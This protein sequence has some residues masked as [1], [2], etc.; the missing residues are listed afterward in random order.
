MKFK[1]KLF[2]TAEDDRGR[3]VLLRQ[4]CAVTHVRCVCARG[5]HSGPPCHVSFSVRFLSSYTHSHT[6]TRTPKVLSSNSMGE[7]GTPLA[8]RLSPSSEFLRPKSLQCVFGGSGTVYRS[9]IVPAVQNSCTK[10]HHIFLVT[11]SVVL[12]SAFSGDGPCIFATSPLRCTRAIG[13]ASWHGARSAARQLCV[14]EG[15]HRFREGGRVSRE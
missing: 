11:L 6:H 9:G 10:Y 3:K 4:A 14:H 12:R 13:C 5:G 7:H 8:E 1:S 2:V 15:S